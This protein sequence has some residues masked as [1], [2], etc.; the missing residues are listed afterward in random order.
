MLNIQ[1]SYARYLTEA[2]NALAHTPVSVERLEEIKSQLIQEE[3]II[4]VIGVFS[5]GKSTALNTLLGRPTLPVDISPET[6]LATELR[7]SSDERVEA[8]RS[9]GSIVKFKLEE[10]EAIKP[11]VDEFSH[12]VLYIDSDVLRRLSPLVLVDMPGFDST[13]ANH[14][15]AISRYIGNG[16]HYLVLISAEEGTI[17]KSLQRHLRDINQLEQ[18]FSFIV[19]KAN[20]K[21]QDELADILARVQDQASLLFGEEITVSAM[22]QDDQEELAT[23]LREIDPENLY[24]RIHGRSMKDLHLDLSGTLGL[25]IAGL[26]QGADDCDDTIQEMQ[27]TLEKIVSK[28]DSILSEVQSRHSDASIH[29]CIHAVET[30][31][32]QAIH[33]L[34]DTAM[35]GDRKA[36]G[37]VVSDIT[38]SVLL[39]EIKREMNEINSTVVDKLTTEVNELYI[40]LN[41]FEIGE[42]WLA[43][44]AERVQSGTQ[45]LSTSIQSFSEKMSEKNAHP[46]SQGDVNH[47]NSVNGSNNENK[48]KT[49][50]NIH[51]YRALTTTLAVTTSIV[52]PL[53]ELV[54]IFLPEL[55]SGLMRKRQREELRRQITSQLI[56]GVKRQLQAKLPEIYNDQVESLVENI[57]ATFENK[58]KEH[59]LTLSK[60]TLEQRDNK[61]DILSQ[62]EHLTSVQQKIQRLASQ[63]LYREAI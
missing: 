39:S 24:E 29:R 1:T 43:D 3:L 20:L 31:L 14:N 60:V 46:A 61:S 26:Q 27:L 19:S 35:S 47:N 21:P 23:R 9:D 51:L 53:I 42:D 38:R 54:I 49:T 7:A 48:D 40:K 30:E 45:R 50:R 12:L 58:I 57:S 44:F 18:S 37:L 25:S 55:L 16:A 13:L 63:H 28:R 11:R 15:K 59:Q 41:G 6:D 5:S 33:E 56:P 32:S 34:T 36:V 22:G 8:I 10:M 62:V 17:T 4:P 2:T 52:I